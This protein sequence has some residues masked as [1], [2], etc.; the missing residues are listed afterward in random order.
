VTPAL[1]HDVRLIAS[2][3]VEGDRDAVQHPVTVAAPR[4]TEARIATAASGIRE[5]R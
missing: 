1:G 3:G 2:A 5:R 4:K